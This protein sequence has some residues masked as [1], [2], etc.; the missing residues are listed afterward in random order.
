MLVS[1]V[2]AMLALG[3]LGAA[4]EAVR[5][6]RGELAATVV[7][8]MF[9]VLALFGALIL[10]AGINMVFC[11]AALRRYPLSYFQRFAARHLVGLLEP[12]WI[13]ILA[14]DLGVAAGFI[15]LGASSFWVALP[16]ALL[17]FS[18]NYLVA[19][20]LLSVIEHLMAT[21]NGPLLLGVLV[22]LLTL[23]PSALAPALARNRAGRGTWLAILRLSPPSA[24]A[25]AVAGA[26]APASA[27]SMLLLLGW[28]AGLIAAVAWVERQPLASRTSAG[29][30]ARWD[31]PCDRVS[32][33]FGPAL[34]PLV[35]KTVRYYI[36]SPQLRLNYP[37]TPPLM[38]LVAFTFGRQHHDPLAGF[39]A[40]L[41]T[42]SVVGCMSMGIMPMNLFGFYGAGFRRY[43]FLPTSPGVV[44]RAV[45]LVPLLLGAPLILVC[46]GLWLVFWP[47]H[48]DGR[49]AVML[50]SNGFGGMFLFQG[51]G[52]WTSL[53][54]P[55]A[56]E[57][58]VRFG[59]KQP[60]ASTA[61]MM[62]EMVVM[63][64]LV[65]GLP[66]LGPKV[67]LGHWWVAPLI[68]LATL[69]FHLFT[70][71]AGARVFSARRERM[72]SMIERGY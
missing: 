16:A 35:G 14:L 46:V 72:L 42:I 38:V 21:R 60:F 66:A 12:L 27:A 10:S 23:L 31:H 29:G 24:A 3:G 54:A 19:R 22:M 17:L 8:T 48:L 44:F 57:F 15:A 39:L 68:L 71:S 56:M 49:M 25:R 32:A 40:I 61:L 53:L 7:L 2:A 11:D 47:G 43:L 36:R 50:L 4:M 9:F 6:G 52:L 51:L 33:A 59:M 45:A 58:K 13:F 1:L 34:A 62:T 37:I 18:T 63:F 55:Q 20:L 41:G 5:L 69:V 70:L 28:C 30:E 64:A 26:P 65:A 67:V